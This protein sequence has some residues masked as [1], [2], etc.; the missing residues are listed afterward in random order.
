M[1]S[2]VSQTNVALGFGFVE[3]E[4]AK[5]MLTLFFCLDI[6]THSAGRGGRCTQLQW[7]T[8]HGR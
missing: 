1:I 5:A 6:L 7:K 3:F 2:P 4:N 8:L